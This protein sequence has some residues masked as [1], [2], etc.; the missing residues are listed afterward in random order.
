[1]KPADAPKPQGIPEHFPGD[2]L[3]DLGDMPNYNDW[4]VSHFA[5]LLGSHSVEI[6]AGLGTISE[7]LRGSVD[8][9]ELVEPSPDLARRLNEK[10]SADDG[11]KV[12]DQTLEK[13]METTQ[14]A[15]FDSIVMVNVLEHIE[16][17]FAAAQGLHDA[18]KDGG[19]LL[20]FVPALPFLYSKL[21]KIYGHYRRYTKPTLRDC[22]SAAGFEIEKLHYVDVAGVIPWWLLNTILGKTSFHG[23][24]LQVY[25]KCVVPV[26]RFCESVLRPPFGK[27]LI[28]I[29]RKN[30]A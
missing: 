3:E 24:S 26:T 16:D 25:D 30:E 7:R 27:N 19:R 20:V 1:M 23:P 5:P 8:R 17:D 13:W 14:P 21:D 11:L 12:F 15:T 22:V 29:A 2:V 6:G 9:L 28:L 18:L 10:F 4:I